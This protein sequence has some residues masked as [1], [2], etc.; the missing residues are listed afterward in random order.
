MIETLRGDRPSDG[1]SIEVNVERDFA[2]NYQNA[3][4]GLV[5][6]LVVR[7]RAG[8]QAAT[9][10]LNLEHVL[11]PDSRVGRQNNRISGTQTQHVGI[12]PA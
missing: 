1:G 3:K 7:S 2:L 11:C 10:I 8:Q 5:T 4:T 12:A 9:S 6:Q